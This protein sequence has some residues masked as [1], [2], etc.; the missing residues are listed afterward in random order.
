MFSIGS[1]V[2][3]RERSR[4]TDSWPF[5]AEGTVRGRGLRIGLD[6]RLLG[7]RP[8]GIGRYVLELCKEL[9]QLLP[10]TEFFLYAPWTIRIPVDSPRWH[11]PVDPWGR[12]FE[13]FRHSWVTKHV[14]MLLRTGNL[15]AR[16][17]VNVF[18][19]TDAPFIP[20]LPREVRVVA[21]VHDLRHRVVPKTMRKAALYGRFA[22]ERRL[23]RADALVTNSAGTAR[24]LHEFL[25]YEAKGI[26][27]P[28]VSASFRRSSETEIHATLMRYSIR[29][30]Y[31]LSV[32]SCD[33]HKNLGALIVAFLAM[34]ADRNLDGY[35]LAL[36]GNKS[37]RLIAE[38]AQATGADTRAIRA[39]GYVRDDDLPALYSGAEVFV[40]PS[41]DEGFGMPVL[42][43]RACRTR[44]VTTDAPEL[45]EAGGDR[46]IYVRPDAE[47][48][49]SGINAALAADP[50]AETDTL[51]T[52]NSSAHVLADA[53]DP[54]R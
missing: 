51:W 4:R 9:D 49:R 18:W 43:A 28:A 16:D 15:C 52:W 44:I 11:A 32:A 45:R 35:S 31:L 6:A 34:K 1:A 8:T 30:P 3:H 25:G 10:G 7:D 13:R 53:L 38:F 50:P 39:L 5:V 41:L 21:T 14:W 42:E 26:A 2:S 33:P 47:G 46:A 23:R 24:K 19:A 27:R 54:Q 29:R 40:L 20:R 48:I 37:E 36:V 22:L 12:I 17:R